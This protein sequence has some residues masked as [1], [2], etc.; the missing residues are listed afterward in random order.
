[1]STIELMSLLELGL[2]YGVMTMGIYL[3]YRILNV[4]DL[5]V[6][7]T[8]TLGAALSVYLCS[9]GHP[10]LGLGLGSCAG[11]VAGMVTALLQT[12]FKIQPI[13]SGI[14]TMTG[15]Y[16]INI[17]AM[18]GKA[19]IA[20]GTKESIFIKLKQV[21]GTGSSYLLLS[22]GIVVLILIFLAIF[23]NTPL[24]LCIR[25]TGDNEEMVKSS[26]IDVDRM[27]IVGLGLANMLVGLSGG[28]IGQY[29]GFSD[30]NM[31]TGMV[32][33][34]LASLIIG[35]SIF[36]NLYELMFK[37]KVLGISL[38][39]VVLGSIGYRAVI[40]GAL[41]LNISP[42]SMK[43]I[44]ASIITLAIAMPTIKAKYKLEKRKKNHQKQERGDLYANIN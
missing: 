26:S 27:K 9:I 32:I 31:G 13:L 7:G 19:N 10:I 34:G 2:L 8:F 28:L 17:W 5:T 41:E 30:A 36:G 24:G 21:M 37:N 12:K 23:L 38:I 25:A 3:S 20:L 39:S 40:W 33:I 16:T 14:L 1:M 18:G 44:S 35:E 42:T 6:D 15:L 4:P 11:G 22:L 43:L 29:Q